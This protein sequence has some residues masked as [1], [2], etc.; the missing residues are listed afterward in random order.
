MLRKHLSYPADMEM[1]LHIA[2]KAGLKSATLAV[3][4]TPTP[5]N[6]DEVVTITVTG[7]TSQKNLIEAMKHIVTVL[8]D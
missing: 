6:N 3:A 2:R 8:G 4:R 1:A 7:L 5:E